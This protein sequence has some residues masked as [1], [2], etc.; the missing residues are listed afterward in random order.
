MDLRLV[1]QFV[2]VA[3]ERNVTRA[4]A[5]VHAAQSTV[6]AGLRSLERELGVRLFDRT[7]RVMT[8][9]PA[10][11][12]VLPQARLALAAGDRMRD[13]AREP[14]RGL[15]G[16][17]RLGI[18]SGL[19]VL[20]LP[21]V[22]AAFRQRH[23]EVDLLLSASQTGSTGLHEDVRRG[24]LDLA[25]SALPDAAR[26]L[27]HEPL[28]RLPFVALLPPGHP[29]AGA[30]SVRLADLAD[31]AWVDT[32]PG[33]A[34]R[35]VM[36]DLLARAGIA[37]RLVV[38]A[39]DLPSVAAFVRAGV[40]VAVL[41]DAVDPVGCVRLPVEDVT[42]PWQLVLVW[43]A[44]PGLGAAASALRDALRRHLARGVSGA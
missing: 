39:G 32:S 7:S 33:Y 13:E 16:R 41:P 8:L 36:E 19:D 38:E 9:T 6:S 10:G 17:V 2:A 4:A 14:E 21:A 27:A 23:P 11:E 30:R 18:F 31:D 28:L 26:G 5:R 35:V 43:R 20:D 1:E 37:R 34:N 29:S 44:D 12:R 15:R 24:R 25:F 42:D 22:V 3:E 40:G